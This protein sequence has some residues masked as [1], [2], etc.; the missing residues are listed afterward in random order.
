MLRR[1]A[2]YFFGSVI[3]SLGACKT[4]TEQSVE[5]D[6]LSTPQIEKPAVIFSVGK[7]VIKA[8]MPLPFKQYQA[9]SRFKNNVRTRGEAAM[10]GVR[11]CT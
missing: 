10:G 9:I 5:S 6:F 4:I 8:G 11:F 7:N 2:Y 1:K 3:L